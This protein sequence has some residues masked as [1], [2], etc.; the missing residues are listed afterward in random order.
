MPCIEIHTNLNIYSFENNNNDY[1][2]LSCENYKPT[3]L[4]CRNMFDNFMIEK[5]GLK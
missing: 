1:Q 5:L 2:S 4:N 3:F